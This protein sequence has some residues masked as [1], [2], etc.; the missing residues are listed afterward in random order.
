MVGDAL[1]YQDA[2]GTELPAGMWVAMR[3]E[4]VFDVASLTKLFT[5][6]RDATVSKTFRDQLPE[7]LDPG[8]PHGLGFRIGEETFM[9]VLA[10]SG[11]VGH[12]GFT[13]TSLVIDSTAAS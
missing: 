9:G 11:A 3:E 8:F 7:G 1:R 4:S 12:T 6:T 2:N 5:A 13:G 10:A